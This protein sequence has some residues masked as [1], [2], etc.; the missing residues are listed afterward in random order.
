MKKVLKIILRVLLIIIG[1]FVIVAGVFAIKG[2]VMWNNA[3]KE[4]SI[5]QAVEKVGYQDA[6]SLS[7]ALRAMGRF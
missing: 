7:R 4:L 5:T 6:A 2:A 1:R 3:K